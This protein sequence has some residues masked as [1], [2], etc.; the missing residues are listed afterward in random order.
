[1][2]RIR[3]P[4]L[5]DLCGLIAIV[6]IWSAALV[7]PMH[8]NAPAFGLSPSAFCG[9]APPD[10]DG[11]HAAHHPCCLQH[12]VLPAALAVRGTCT[13]ARF[14][15]HIAQPVAPIVSARPQQKLIRAPPL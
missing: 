13:P 7:A 9:E 2:K 3:L 1:M 14:A 8:A 12:V 6:V 11:P 15:R 5:R 10:G 4:F